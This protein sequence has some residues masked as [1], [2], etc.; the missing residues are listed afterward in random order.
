MA[1]ILIVEDSSTQALRLS[2]LLE[3]EGHRVRRAVDGRDALRRIAEQRPE[4]VISD[5][6]MPVMNG[7]ELCTHLKSQ[8]ETRQ[9]PVLLL[10]NLADPNDLIYGLNAKADSYVTKPY[11]DQFLLMRVVACLENARESQ[12][13]RFVEDAPLEI[14][15]GGRQ[16]RI[17]ATR[18]QILQIFLTTYENSLLQNRILEK[19]QV[20][21]GELNE[22][23]TE[24][25]EGL[26]ASEAQF[27]GLVQ[28]I[29]DIVYK[30]DPDGCFSFLNDSISR[31]GY[32]KQ[33][34]LGRHFSEI[35]HEEDLEEVSRERVM[36]RLSGQQ[37][38]SQPKLFDERR[39]GDRMTTGLEVRLKSRSGESEYASIIP[40]SSQELFVEV[41]SSGLYGES[42]W[43]GRQYIGTVGVIRDITDR[44][45]GQRA[46]E[47][48]R[49]FLGK[50]INAVPMP[51][52]FMD[53]QRE[54]KLAN[55]SFLQFFGMESEE[56]I[57]QCGALL[58]DLD[59][60][61]QIMAS[62]LA[63]L[64][65]AGQETLTFETLLSTRDAGARELIVTLAKFHE[66][67][68]ETAGVIGVLADVTAQREAEKRAILAKEEAERMARLAESANQAKSDFLANMSHEIRT[69]MNAIIGLSHLALQ[70]EMT[71]RQRNYIQKVNRSAESL[72][73][74]INDILDF[75]KIEAGKLTLESVDFRLE[76]ILDNLANLVGLQVQEKGLELHFA[77]DPALPTSLLGDPLRLG[78]V[79]L[80]LG[81]NAVKFTERGEIVVRLRQQAV[82][83]ERILLHGSVQDSGIG[84]TPEQQGR[85]FSSFSQA[86]GSTTRK[87]GGTG[88]G[89]A[90][91]KKLVEMMGGSIWVESAAGQGSTF[92]FTVWLGRGEAIPDLRPEM[93]RDLANL[94]VLV[95]DDNHTAREIVAQL[96]R[97]MG[98][99][100]ESTDGGQR[101]LAMLAEAEAADD[102]VKFLLL[103]WQMPGMDG[104][105]TVRALQ[106][107]A[108]LAHP[109]LV[110]MLTAYGREDAIQAAGDLEI[111]EFLSK[112]V[113]A[114]SLLDALM[115][116]LGREAV[117]GRRA[118]Q[119]LEEEQEAVQHLRGARVLLVEDNEINQELALE[120]LTT[121]GMVVEVANNGLEALEK[122]AGGAFDGVLMDVQMPV[123]DGYTATQE[124]RKQAAWQP[125]PVI[126]MTAN[127]MAGDREKAIAAGMND[128]I[129]KPINVREMFTSMARWI[130]PSAQAGGNLAQTPAR[131]QEEPLPDLPAALPG[132]DLQE[133]LARCNGD[134]ALYRRLLGKF[135]DNQ[136][137]VLERVRGELERGARED[138]VR[139]LHTLRGVAGTLGAQA[140]QQAAQMLESAL[141]AGDHPVEAELFAAVDSQLASVLA[142]CRQ[143]VSR[144]A[145][146]GGTASGQAV[147]AEALRGTLA[148]LQG[149]LEESDTDAL[150]VVEKLTALLAGRPELLGTL[151][152]LH[153]LIGQYDFD[154]ALEA[155]QVL[156][157]Q[158]AIFTTNSGKQGTL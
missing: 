152:S 47:N 133:G 43:H 32:D 151:K 157:T 91:S 121:A 118:N 93:D 78:Q 146:S 40:M 130:A 108:A 156:L 63:L 145:A 125:L 2:F 155:A 129:A 59:D 116:A 31:L 109:P 50:L 111:R 153:Q 115:Q 114:S 142:G 101:A 124:I 60:F 90:I 58:R 64:A 9:I 44:K 42:G 1:D 137:A 143:A 49:A 120:L 81:N 103:D 77:V 92:H 18:E 140:L 132:I 12:Y 79:L 136:A 83:G 119:R 56:K 36:S 14:Q 41:N 37:A 57:H 138:A 3:G 13:D 19:Q 147:D 139:Q 75:S 107:N 54:I 135:L 76:D 20:A 112:P 61:R 53:C 148:R 105:A 122:L 154:A 95:V 70:T 5:I 82:E 104:V 27:R 22:K 73:G 106:Q 45:R 55:Y 39:I 141:Q 26:E 113:S 74:I 29:P 98:L 25:L 52:F 23:L 80:N 94:R 16:H 86:D 89:L 84:M 96:A 15:F 66:S 48:E 21:M 72:L 97:S 71:L 28:T 6:T 62:C 127:A 100:V 35:I 33:T 150:E 85:I 11:D 128:H 7:F 67:G 117:S 69:P 102:P 123:M 51:I 149:L 99:R 30:L 144:P 24:S 65:D 110:I 131:Q 4:I 87:F 134:V 88:L 34:L 68:Q 17:T 46:L 126:A 158:S 8:A 10:T 38:A